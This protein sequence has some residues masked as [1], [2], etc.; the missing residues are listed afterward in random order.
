M[1]YEFLIRKNE[2]Y[3]KLYDDYNKILNEKR[4][5]LTKTNNELVES[6]DLD[7]FNYSQLE[8]LIELIG[9]NIDNK[10]KKKLETVYLHKKPYTHCVIEKMDFLD[11]ESKIKLDFN[12]SYF[13]NRYIIHKFWYDLRVDKDTQE[14]IIDLLLK[15]GYLLEHYYIHCSKCHDRITIF[16]EKELENLN[17]FTN[18][19]KEIS[20]YENKSI[21]D[22]LTDKDNFS[23]DKLYENYYDIEEN[24]NPLYH[25]CESCEYENEFD[26]QEELFRHS[27]KV[28]YI[29]DKLKVVK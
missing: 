9:Y 11:K 27:T 13:R 26:N 19:K 4:T 17:E 12:L 1:S 5:D 22:G 23:L 8:T 21:N 15:E 18:I 25:Y 10:L 29:V 2:E 16:R 7:K 6:L 28:Y 14:K 3:K 20:N 24:D